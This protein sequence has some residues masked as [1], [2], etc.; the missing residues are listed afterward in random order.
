MDDFNWVIYIN[1]YDDLKNNKID[2]KEKA[3][4]HYKN[5]GIKEGRNCILEYF[6]PKMYIHYNEDLKNK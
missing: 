1:K 3:L 5:Y 2:T 6:D 4:N